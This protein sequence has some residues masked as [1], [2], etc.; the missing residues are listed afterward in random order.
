MIYSSN[1]VQ[2]A[3]CYIGLVCNLCR[4]ASKADLMNILC[5]SSFFVKISDKIAQLEKKKHGLKANNQDLLKIFIRKLLLDMKQIL[6]TRNDLSDIAE[7]LFNLQSNPPFVSL[8][9]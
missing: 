2:Y 6:S 7:S 4:S 8:L 5:R 9:G 1:N 3:N